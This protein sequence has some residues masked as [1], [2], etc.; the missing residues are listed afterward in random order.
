[1]FRDDPELAEKYLNQVLADGQ[2]GEL[3][4]AMRYL[5]TASAAFPGSRVRPS[6]MR[7]RFTCAVERYVRQR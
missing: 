7:A 3:L 4:L 6:S 5:A 2:R 1:M